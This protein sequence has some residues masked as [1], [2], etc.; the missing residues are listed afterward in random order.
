D[1]L[2]GGLRDSQE[3]F[4]GSSKYDRSSGRR[5]PGGQPYT[6]M[7]KGGGP[8]GSGWPLAKSKALVPELYRVALAYGI[9][10]PTGQ[11][12]PAGRWRIRNVVTWG[13]PNPPSGA[14]RGKVRRA[15]SA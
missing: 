6:D 10:P 4:V 12:S 2:P 9:N 3:P 7:F 5:A 8:G 13:R 14:V 15:T 1:Y 11:E